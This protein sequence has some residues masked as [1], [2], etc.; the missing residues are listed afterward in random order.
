MRPLP[1]IDSTAIGAVA[2]SLTW[3][4][5]HVVEVVILKTPSH[6][7]VPA[8]TGADDEGAVLPQII[9]NLLFAEHS[10][11]TIIG[12]R[13]TTQVVQDLLDTAC[14]SII[15]V[16]VVTSSTGIFTAVFVT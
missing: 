11:N 4:G 14:F 2:E 8:A 6:N 7:K 16:P 5:I 15:V 1:S 10:C 9:G 3:P 12:N 13:R